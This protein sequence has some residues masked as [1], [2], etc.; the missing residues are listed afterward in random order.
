MEAGI[1]PRSLILQKWLFTREFEI[2]FIL[3][4]T[5]IYCVK[6][7]CWNRSEFEPNQITINIIYRA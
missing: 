6:L 3:I 2:V 1:A 7:M 5:A 4:N